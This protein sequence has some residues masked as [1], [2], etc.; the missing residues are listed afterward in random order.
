MSDMYWKEPPGSGMRE[1]KATRIFKICMQ[2]LRAGGNFQRIPEE[3]R[4][5]NFCTKAVRQ[6][7]LLLDS[8]PK[9]LRTPELCLAA[10]KK[11]GDALQHVP[12]RLRT[13][14]LCMAAVRQRGTALHYVPATQRTLELCMEAVR[15]ARRIWMAL[16]DVPTRHR[17][18]ELCRFAV[19]QHS[20]ALEYVP[21]KLR[22]PELC[23]DALEHAVAD[24]HEW[25]PKKHFQSASF[26]RAV[27]SMCG[28]AIH[29]V[30]EKYRTIELHV[31]AAKTSLEEWERLPS[32]SITS[33]FCLEVV[34]RNAA[35]LRHVPPHM[36]S[37]ELCHAAAGQWNGISHV[38][39]EWR[40]PALYMEAVRRHGTMLHFVPRKQRSAELC[41]EAV[42]QDGVAL[43]YVPHALRSEEI[44][45]TAVAQSRRWEVA[46]LFV[47]ARLC[48][49]K[50]FLRLVRAHGHGKE[51]IGMRDLCLGIASIAYWYVNV[52]A[53]IP[54]RFRTEEVCLAAILT[55]M[56]WAALPDVPRSLRTRGLCNAAIDC[57]TGLFFIG[58]CKDDAVLKKAHTVFQLAAEADG[59]VLRHAPEK[60]ITPELCETAVRQNGLALEFVPQKLRTAKL[61]IVAIRQNGRAIKHVPAQLRSPE[62]CQAAALSSVHHKNIQAPSWRPQ[63]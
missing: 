59:C 46:A 19:R 21:R 15:P 60:L 34:K 51:S 22:T 47:P 16:Q 27:I 9:Y 57:L 43:A 35:A 10:V 24:E 54:P 55:G 31:E 2:G 8:F 56:G 26:C 12:Q 11:N 48:F 6:H 62:L 32:E 58:L 18:P 23:L 45:V 33:Q 14:E 13:P 17:T 36:L 52:L 28:W 7:G 29:L 50:R 39:P 20:S 40:T 1:T 49:T 63:T 38:P 41:L 5:R 44:C 37:A 25:I 53:K 61:C 30:P 42:R 4:T 3:Y